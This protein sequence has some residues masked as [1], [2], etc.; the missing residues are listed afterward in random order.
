MRCH[1]EVSLRG[2]NVRSQYEDFK[3]SALQWNVKPEPYTDRQQAESD[4]HHRVGIVSIVGARQR[5][6]KA[7]QFADAGQTVRRQR[8]REAVSA[9]EANTA[10]SDEFFRDF[11]FAEKMWRLESEARGGGV[12]KHK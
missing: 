11:I 5:H 10:R 9:A 6:H 8:S 2:V 4:M 7:Q 12:K 1:Y 3:R